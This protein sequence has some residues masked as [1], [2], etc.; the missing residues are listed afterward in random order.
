MKT[1]KKFICIIMVSIMIFT[2][3]SISSF[4][5]NPT[6]E[7]MRNYLSEIGTPDPVVASY[8]DATVEMIYSRLYGK[9]V[10]FSNIETKSYSVPNSS[11]V[12]T[13]GTIDSDD[14]YITMMYYNELDTSIPGMH[15]V[16][17]LTVF[18]V[19]NWSNVPLIKK[20]DPVAINW[21]SSLF[22]YKANSF[23]VEFNHTIGSLHQQYGSSSVVS[24]LDQG[25]LGFEV[26]LFSSVYPNLTSLSGRATFTLLPKQTIYSYG[27]TGNSSVTTI[28]TNYT[29]NNDTN[30]FFGFRFSVSVAGII[31]I[32][33]EGEADIMATGMNY[34]Y[35]LP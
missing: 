10:A 34:F 4:A 19:Y 22:A 12:S 2:S 24:I 6:Q 20:Y 17:A 13:Y 29:H 25:G 14:F 3:F 15:K 1:I 7:E 35:D 32:E 30:N 16:T 21:D 11:P 9:N 5:V 31:G 18:M 26:D 23:T 28:N 27:S 33:Y 8:D